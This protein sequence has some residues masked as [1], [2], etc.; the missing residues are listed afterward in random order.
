VS[1]ATPIVKEDAV[2]LR[3]HR[4][5]VIQMHRALAHYGLDR[6]DLIT[7]I[8]LAI[9]MTFI[10]ILLLPVASKFWAFVIDTGVRTLPLNAEMHLAQYHI[11][12]YIRF[13]I[14]YPAME[15]ILPDTRMW[16]VSGVVTLLLF[17][18]TYFLPS[19]L[20]PVIY[21]VRGVLFIQA[22]AQV[23]FALIP[24]EF[25]HTP[26]GYLE[27]LFM[28][29]MALISTVPFLLGMTFYIFDYSL[30]KK[31]LLTAMTMGHLA[32]FLPLQ[33][34]LQGLVLQKTVLF[35]PVLY[36]IFGLPLDVLII[37][38]FYSWGMTWYFKSEE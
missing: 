38:G 1:K 10:W 24:A 7:S 34:L 2:H 28:A 11:T 16:V 23:Y 6:A 15:A 22:S 4:G 14:P 29:G 36:I 19:E 20:I 30:L 12:P 31:I 5:G 37:I 25:P 26:N 35:M 13:V 21:L 3:G 8:A 9:L 18:A 17:V 27:G 33:I 32:V